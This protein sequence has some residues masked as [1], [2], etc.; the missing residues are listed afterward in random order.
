MTWKRIY[1][2]PPH[3][4]SEWVKI[5]VYI[6][7]VSDGVE[8][9]YHTEGILED[10]NETLS[11]HI[12]ANGNFSCDCNRY[13]FFQHAADEQ[14]VDENCKCGHGGYLV[15]IVNPINKETVYDE[16]VN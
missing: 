11:T 8:R 4:T 12:W 5:D 6:R 16:R 13:L 2:E 1:H 9:I 10:D 7:R 3:N 14:E 15:W